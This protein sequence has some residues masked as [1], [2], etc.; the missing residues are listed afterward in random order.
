MNSKHFPDQ[1]VKPQ[2]FHK[3]KLNTL[4]SR[5]LNFWEK[6]FEN[7]IE[8]HKEFL[9]NNLEDQNTYA[10]K[11]SQILQSDLYI[12]SNSNHRNLLRQDTFS[13]N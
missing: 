11:F 10:S 5:M 9:I 8:K 12:V 13:P 1:I 4:T 6:D 2:N 3:I 7:S